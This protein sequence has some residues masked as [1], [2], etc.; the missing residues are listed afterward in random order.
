MIHGD[1]IMGI[2][3]YSPLTTVD[4]E[5]VRHCVNGWGLCSSASPRFPVFRKEGTYVRRNSEERE[6]LR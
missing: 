5:I 3:S 6:D 1:R 2:V 4:T